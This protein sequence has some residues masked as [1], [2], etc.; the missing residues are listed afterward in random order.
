[1]STTTPFEQFLK[2]QLN[3][4]QKKAVKHDKGSLLVIAGA[5]SGKTRVITARIA[6]LILHK[7]VDPRSIVA[8][9]FTNKAAREME[10]RV[11]SFLD[12]QYPPPFI[13]T[14]HAYCLRLLKQ[15]RNLLTIPDFSIM[16][17]DDQLKI[18]TGIIARTHLKQKVS[19]KELLYHISKLKSSSIH[20]IAAQPEQEY[21]QIIQ[22]VAQLYE[23]EKRAS[24]CLDFD[25]LLLEVVRLFYKHEDFKNYIHQAVEHILVDEYQDTN[26]VQHELLKLMSKE[27]KKIVA[28]SVCVVGDEDQSIYSWRGATV[29]NIM[30]FKKDFPRTTMVTIEQNY[31]SVQPILEIANKVIAYNTNRNPKKLWSAKEAR[32][33][34]QLMTCISGYQEAELVAQCI[35]QASLK[36]S[37]NS[38]AI[39]YRTHFQSRVI[40][41]ALIRSSIPYTIIGGIQFYAR[42][43]I[44]DIL[45]YLRLAINPFDRISFK[46]VINCPTRGLGTKFQEQFI[47]TWEQEPLLD[48]LQLSTKLIEDKEIK[49]VKKDSVQEFCGTITRLQALELPTA[50]I[51]QLLVRINYIQYLKD[52]FDKREAEEK[53]ENVREFIRATA[54]FEQQGITTV[55]GL[56]EEITLMQEK[57]DKKANND[58]VQLMTLHAAKGLEFDTVLLTGL[59]EGLL[60]SARSLY[61]S[62]SVEEERRL[63]Y[64]GITRAQERLVITHARMRNSYGSTNDQLVSRFVKEMPSSLYH[65]NDCCSWQ[66]YQLS[67]FFADWYGNKADTNTVL[68]FGLAHTPSNSSR[69]K[70]PTHPHPTRALTARAQS[71]KKTSASRIKNDFMSILKKNVDTGWRINQPVQHKTFGIG[72]VKKAE[73]KGTVTYVTAQ[74]KTGTKKVNSDFLTRV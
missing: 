12:G 73:K 8:L 7:Q 14:F 19:P 64:V 33:R 68:T 49:G 41:E 32:N 9:T 23:K 39:L 60:P 24:K 63:F 55:R 6:Y 2:T 30:N 50:A 15:N 22:D 42:K 62:E 34:V 16:D 70:R 21:D 38:I 36:Q 48:C 59:E 35:K 56:L 46:R 1:M 25:D 65:A 29:A 57:T 54:H 52:S 37:R 61:D 74:F 47:E 26:H 53:I 51:E 17:A 11:I 40:E 72:I 45:A 18:V 71:S 5:G 43:E 31:R 44:K 27:G 69:K 10:Q 3:E 58:C 4:Q 13:G 67:R 28:K 66:S 20:G